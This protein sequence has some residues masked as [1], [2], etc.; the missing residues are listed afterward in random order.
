[1]HGYLKHARGRRDVRGDALLTSVGEG[2]L[3]VPFIG[4][5]EGMVLAAFRET[6]LPLQRIRA[7]LARLDVNTNCSSR[8]PLSISIPTARRS[9]TTTPERT[10]T[11]SSGF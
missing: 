4:L 7:A 2:A 3:T 6:G 10:T 5:A 8:S 9:F 1:M 11:N